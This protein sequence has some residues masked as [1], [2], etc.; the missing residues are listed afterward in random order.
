[1][2]SPSRSPSSQ[3]LSTP[4]AHQTSKFGKT[5]GRSKNARG[6]VQWP[7]AWKPSPRAK[8]ERRITQALGSGQMGLATFGGRTSRKQPRGVGH[9]PALMPAA[10]AQICDEVL[11]TLQNTLEPDA[12]LQPGVRRMVRLLELLGDVPAAHDLDQVPS[13]WVVR[14][15]VR[16]VVD[17]AMDRDPCVASLAIS[18][19]AQLVTVT[20]AR[21]AV[22]LALPPLPAML[23]N[24]PAATA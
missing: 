16:H 9:A 21:S 11:A 18:V 2:I 17:E 3:R 24:L 23:A 1:M 7:A 10:G 15:V 8:Q 19:A 12:P 6:G 13:A 4:E 5:H 22:P 14:Q 20:T